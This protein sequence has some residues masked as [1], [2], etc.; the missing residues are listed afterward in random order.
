[1]TF[2]ITA[3][4]EDE[5]VQKALGIHP[6]QEREWMDRQA[7]IDAR[8][9]WDGRQEVEDTERRLHIATEFYHPQEA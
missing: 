7:E 1:M 2:D 8:Q 6:D 9:Q 4:L 3:D 5:A